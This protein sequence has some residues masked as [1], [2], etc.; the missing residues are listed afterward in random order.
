MKPNFIYIGTG[1]AGSTWLFEALQW[2]PDVYVTEV[3]ETNF[4]DLN[5]HRG[6]AWYEEFFADTQAHAVGE[7]AHRYLRHP[8]VARRILDALGPTR[9]ITVFRR[10]EDYAL[11]WYLFSRRNGRFDGTPDAWI[12]QCFEHD[13][14]RYMSLLRPF[15]EA[16]GRENI[17]VGCFDDL[18]DA[19]GMFFSEVCRFLEVAPFDLPPR[20]LGRS[21]AAASPRS[22]TLALL[23]N[24]VSGY[25]K[26]RGGQRL[27]AVVKRQPL[28]QALLYKP[29][30]PVERPGFSAESR[31]LIRAIAE[32][33]LRALDSAV[34][35]RLTERW[36]GHCGTAAA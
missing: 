7:I 21:N 12:E 32:P 14:V 13:S 26:T 8:E 35:T 4:F 27:I 18:H 24:R 33:E 36:Y 30:L 9:C 34:G 17:F 1:K 10:P 25:L 19:P 23:V 5:L 20:L 3:K 16:M 29:L 6:L 2:H 22:S 15:L 31:E 28:V 11:S